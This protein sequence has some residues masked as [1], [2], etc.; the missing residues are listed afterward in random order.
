M[1]MT[2]QELKV[3]VA[4]T[5]ARLTPMLVQDAVHA[6]LHQGADVGGGVN[7][8]RL[9]KYLLDQ[10]QLTDVQTVWAYKR[11]KPALRSAFEHIPSLYFFEGD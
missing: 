4:E 9:V 10:P 2:Q 1:Q 5:I 6:L 3:Q 7:A 11:L 8:S